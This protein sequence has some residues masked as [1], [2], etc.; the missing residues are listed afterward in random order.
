MMLF[1]FCMPQIIGCTL[2][3][4][5][6]VTAMQTTEIIGKTVT[7]IIKIYGM[8]IAESHIRGNDRIDSVLHY[9]DFSVMFSDGVAVEVKQTEKGIQK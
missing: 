2:T 3:D 4:K 1:M 5:Q 6:A 7:E 8:P 9:P